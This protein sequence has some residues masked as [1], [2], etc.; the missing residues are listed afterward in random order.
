MALTNVQE[1]TFDSWLS[2]LSSITSSAASSQGLAKVFTCLEELLGKITDAEV[3]GLANKLTEL[4][5]AKAAE[6]M[7]IF[8]GLKLKALPDLWQ[9]TCKN[10]VD[11][12][13]VSKEFFQKVAGTKAKFLPQPKGGDEKFFEECSNHILPQA[14]M[15]TLKK[16]AGYVSKPDTL[17]ELEGT[18]QLDRFM[19]E[20]AGVIYTLVTAPVDPP[21]SSLVPFL[22]SVVKQIEAVMGTERGMALEESFK[23]SIRK[24]LSANVGDRFIKA[25][26][27]LFAAVTAMEKA[28]PAD[29]EKLI[30]ARNISQLKASLF[31]KRTHEAV[32]GELELAV[33]GTEALS[34]AVKV[35]GHVMSG[36]VLGQIRGHEASIKSLRTYSVSVHGV[37][38]LLHKL[39]PP[40]GKNHQRAAIIREQLGDFFKIVFLTQQSLSTRLTK[41]NLKPLCF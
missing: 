7:S 25:A 36:Q 22:A 18:F 40:G 6:C 33:A 31:S 12:M 15:Q 9:V 5:H 39:P 24:Y 29:Y 41:P 16:M 11:G 17:K 10:L 4:N 26:A 20:T 37:Y 28:I 34:T 13:L 2:Q 3:E 30:E 23:D 35:A 21:L 14:Q 19:V 1:C 8:K 27:K 38:L 32:T